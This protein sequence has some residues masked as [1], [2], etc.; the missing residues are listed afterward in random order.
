MDEDT[1][2]GYWGEAPGDMWFVAFLLD[3]VEWGEYSHNRGMRR[4]I[5][6]ALTDKVA[7]CYNRTW[8]DRKTGHGFMVG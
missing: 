6:G 3:V 7:V 5:D 2:V 1:A 4:Q 8:R